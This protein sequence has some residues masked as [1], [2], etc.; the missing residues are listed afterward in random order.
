MTTSLGIDNSLNAELFKLLKTGNFCV[1][2][3]FLSF[4][5]FNLLQKIK[6][7]LR[8]IFLE[9][10]FPLSRSHVTCIAIFMPVILIISEVFNIYIKNVFF[11]NLVYSIIDYINR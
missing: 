6:Q 5:K 8:P 2:F 10:P 7:K 9:T 11:Q 4:L 1:F 3:L